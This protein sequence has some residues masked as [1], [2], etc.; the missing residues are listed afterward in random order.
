MVDSHVTL[1]E[2]L[3]NTNLLIFPQSGGLLPHLTQD[4]AIGNS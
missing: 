2:Q 4:G 1:V 3:K